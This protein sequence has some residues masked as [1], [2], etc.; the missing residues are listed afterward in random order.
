MTT[1]SANALAYLSD[2]Q[3]SVSVTAGTGGIDAYQ[4]VMM[5]GDTCIPA[6]GTNPTHAGLVFGMAVASIPEGEDG[7]II[8]SGEIENHDWDLDP[9]EIYYV[10]LAGT[11]NKTPPPSGFWQKLGV[12]KDSVTLMLNLGEPIKVM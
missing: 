4:V 7:S 10:S 12:A 9:G 3:N 1:S 11:I 8:M 6:D 5:S 2:I